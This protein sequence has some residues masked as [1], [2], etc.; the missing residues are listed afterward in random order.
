M[1]GDD[2]R[3]RYEPGDLATGLQLAVRIAG[4]ALVPKGLRGKPDDV[5]LIMAQGAELGLSTMQALRGLHVIEGR[6]TLSADLMVALCVASPVCEYFRCVEQSAAGATWEAKRRGSEPQRLTFSLEDAR[7]A[8]LQD[9]GN[10]RSWPGRMCSARAK[11]F[12][13]RDVFPDIVGGLYSPDEIRPGEPDPELAVARV[14]VEPWAPPRLEDL[15][16]R[17]IDVEPDPDDPALFDAGDHIRRASEALYSDLPSAWRHP[18]HAAR[19]IAKRHAEL[20]GDAP[21]TADSLAAA[22]AAARAKVLAE[23]P[24]PA[25]APAEPRVVG[26]RARAV[27]AAMDEDARAEALQVRETLQELLGLSESEA[28]YLLLAQLA[29][30]LGDGDALTIEDVRAAGVAVRLAAE[31][32][33]L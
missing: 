19:S 25:A 29:I 15:D 3:L 1:S 9:K 21:M 16:E 30:R 6:V 17:P 14:E 26:G 23:A 8:G 32:E 27:A 11:A 12:L 20:F 33:I 13:A 2:L 7:R 24:D 4:A 31:G 28:R 5:F 18:R 22:I 10:W